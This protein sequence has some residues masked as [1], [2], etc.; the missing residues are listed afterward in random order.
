MLSLAFDGLGCR[1]KVQ[2]GFDGSWW[3][4]VLAQGVVLG[5]NYQLNNGIGRARRGE[6]VW[7][8]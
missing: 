7:S 3:E 5:W 4:G 6:L 2:P 8:C 1:V